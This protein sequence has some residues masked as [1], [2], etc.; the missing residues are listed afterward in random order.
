MLV[1]SSTWGGHVV[2]DEHKFAVYSFLI[3]SLF[4]YQSN[5]LQEL[6]IEIRW[7]YKY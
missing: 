6:T 3:L 5:Y 7:H 1:N 2:K 4:I